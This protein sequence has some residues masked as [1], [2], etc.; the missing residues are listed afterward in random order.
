V[1]EEGEP[2]RE[3]IGRI[4]VDPEAHRHTSWT[5]RSSSRRWSSS[6]WSR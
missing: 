2:L 6:G 3:Q 4:R 1:P 5:K